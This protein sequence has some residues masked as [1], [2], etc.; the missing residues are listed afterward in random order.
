MIRGNYLLVSWSRL[1]QKSATWN[2]C[3]FYCAQTSQKENLELNEKLVKVS[4]IGLPNSGKST[5]INSMLQHRVSNK[6][7]DIILQ[8]LINFN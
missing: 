7:E 6:L 2:S 8:Q 3:R 5:F 1:I 4:I